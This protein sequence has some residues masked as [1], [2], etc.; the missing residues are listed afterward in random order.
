MHTE[1][2]MH[3]CLEAPRTFGREE[4]RQ[5]ECI[6]RETNKPYHYKNQTPAPSSGDHSRSFFRGKKY[7]KKNDYVQISTIQ[8]EQNAMRLVL[9][10]IL[11]IIFVANGRIDI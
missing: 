6:D 11:R 2:R 9:D 10:M 1:I 8:V 3:S 5:I 4:K 7:L